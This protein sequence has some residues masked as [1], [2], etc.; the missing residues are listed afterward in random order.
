ME[1]KQHPELQ[2]DNITVLQHLQ[3]YNIVMFFYTYTADFVS[4]FCFSGS[5]KGVSQLFLRDDK[6]PAPSPR[7]LPL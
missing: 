2:V 4:L 5:K 7:Y 6:L 3:Y 1:E